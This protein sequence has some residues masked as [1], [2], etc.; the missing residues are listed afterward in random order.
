MA[1]SNPI[2]FPIKS[3]SSYMISCVANAAY[4]QRVTIKDQ[5][6][7]LGVF[8]GSGEGVQLK[9]VGTQSTTIRGSTRQSATMTAYFE[10]NEGAGFQASKVVGD[11]AT[12]QGEVR[13]ITAEDST[14]HDN[15]D[16]ILTIVNMP[17]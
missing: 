17:L 4:T 8:E 13:T 12:D 3:D 5:A 1:F 7:V 10:H 11:T 9:L 15:N 14:D 2:S 6:E 16:S